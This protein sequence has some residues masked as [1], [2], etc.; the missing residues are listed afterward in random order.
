MQILGD[1]ELA[2]LQKV[3][4]EK[5]SVSF[6]GRTTREV[7]TNVLAILKTVEVE[8]QGKYLGLPSHIGR[9]KK[10]VFCFV[11]VKAEGKIAGWKGKMLS[12][13]G[14]EI[15]VKSIAATIPNYVINCFKLPTGIIGELNKVMAIFF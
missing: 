12:Q 6:E 13:A 11:R 5:C 15:L 14:K 3:N 4:I 9:T 10:D 7:R 1:Y 8:D 2:S